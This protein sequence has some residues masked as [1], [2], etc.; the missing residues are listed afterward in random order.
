M[1]AQYFASS[2]AIPTTICG[3]SDT[4]KLKTNYI[5][6][7]EELTCG[8]MTAYGGYMTTQKAPTELGKNI[9]SCI[10]LSGVTEKA[11]YDRLG[12][13]RNTYKKRLASDGFTVQELMRIADITGFHIANI[14]PQS[15][16]HIATVAA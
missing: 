9:L 4:C 15:M 8:H 14:L 2:I 12:V 16:T 10:H 5:S 11:V 6:V 3:Q 13:T 7:I 1:A